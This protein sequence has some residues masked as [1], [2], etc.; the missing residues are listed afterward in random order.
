VRLMQD[1]Y[2]VSSRISIF[3][4]L[5]LTNARLLRK[6]IDMNGKSFLLPHTKMDMMPMSMVS[7]L[8]AAKGLC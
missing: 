8:T 5:L 7:R 2:T 1:D 4:A 3:R 6:L